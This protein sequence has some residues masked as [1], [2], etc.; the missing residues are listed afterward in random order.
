[1]SWG[2]LTYNI[3]VLLFLLVT[4]VFSGLYAASVIIRFQNVFYLADVGVAVLLGVLPFAGTGW[5]RKYKLKSNFRRY[6]WLRRK[7][8][9]EEEL[10]SLYLLGRSV[11]GEAADSDK[12]LRRLSNGARFFIIP[13]SILFTF[14]PVTGMP[15]GTL[16]LWLTCVYTGGSV[17]FLSFWLWRLLRRVDWLG[18]SPCRYY[19][20][21]M[22]LSD[23]ARLSQL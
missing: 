13:G 2:Y 4:A 10:I 15:S 3:G 5:Y 7:L 22:L 20:V 23:I 17:A 14:I 18:V 21:R 11:C 1:M 9:T 6:R 19:P 8:G 12:T 16:F